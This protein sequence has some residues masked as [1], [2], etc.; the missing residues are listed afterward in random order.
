MFIIFRDPLNLDICNFQLKCKKQIK[1]EIYLSN[2][3]NS[4]D[5]KYASEEF[6]VNF[7]A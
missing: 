2:V 3:Q 5:T 7:N 1:I 6:L 4:D